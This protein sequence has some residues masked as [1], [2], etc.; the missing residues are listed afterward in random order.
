[1]RTTL[2][3]TDDVAARLRAEARRSG[4]PFKD[5]VNECLRRGLAQRDQA[6]AGTHFEV[7]PRNMGP[8]QP[9]LSLDNVAELLERIE[10][11]EQA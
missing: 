5:I 6:R 11:L 7:K 8:L 2:T 10:G 3:L 9:G 1:V 4:R